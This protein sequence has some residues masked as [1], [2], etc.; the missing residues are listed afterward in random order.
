MWKGNLPTVFQWLLGKY[1]HHAID[2]TTLLHLAERHR[3]LL[4]P[5]LTASQKNTYSSKFLNICRNQFLEN[6]KQIN[7]VHYFLKELDEFLSLHSLQAIILKGV[8]IS[9]NYYPEKYMRHTRDVDILVEQDWVLFVSEWLKSKGYVLKTDVFSLNSRQRNLFWRFNHHFY[10]LGTNEAYPL[11]VELHWRLRLND[12]V[13]NIN[14]FNK[15]TPLLHTPYQNVFTLHHVDQF[16]YLCVHGTE[17]SWYR[18]KWLLD[19]PFM[20]QYIKFDW[21]TLAMRAVQLNAFVHVKISIYLINRLTGNMITENVE[22]SS[23][24]PVVKRIAA[25]ISKRMNQPSLVE[26]GAATIIRQCF[27]LST[28]NKRRYN[29][30]YWLQWWTSPSDWIKFPLPNQIFFLYYPMRPLFWIIRKFFK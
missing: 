7:K 8:F 17:H 11:H 21:N 18:L 9:E 23:F 10:F 28:F 6:Y 4:F 5:F 2:E 30:N 16:I 26:F 1:E 14:P 12:D 3:I 13:C 29:V 25:K 24:E 27:Y 22:I 20:T 19:L 15:N